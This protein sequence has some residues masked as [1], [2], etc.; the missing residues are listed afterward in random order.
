MN[1]WRWL[2]SVLVWLSAE[3]DGMHLEHARAAAAVS[4]ARASMVVE[5]P[6]PPPPDQADCDCGKTCVRG[7]WK[8]DTKIP[9]ACKCQCQRCVAERAKGTAANCPSG[10]CP[11]PSPVRK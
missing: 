2:I 7:I 9:Q 8:P 10:T 4:A 5:S 11:N 1:L 6:A 3:P